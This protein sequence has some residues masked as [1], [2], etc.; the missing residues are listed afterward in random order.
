MIGWILDRLKGL[1]GKNNR[2][3]VRVKVVIVQST[4]TK[5]TKGRSRRRR[6]KGGPGGSRP[7]A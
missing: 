7:A 1:F 6:G 3:S 5:A 4:Q 2:D